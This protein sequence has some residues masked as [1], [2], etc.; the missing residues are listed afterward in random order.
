MTKMDPGDNPPESVPPPGGGWGGARGRLASLKL[1]LAVQ[2]K[3]T[4]A[5]LFVQFP[6]SEMLAVT[7]TVTGPAVVQMNVG[8]A[9]AVPLSVPLPVPPAM[10]HEKLTSELL[11]LLSTPCAKR[12]MTPPTLAE[13]GL[14]ERDETAAHAFA[15]VTV[16]PM[17]TDPL[18]PASTLVAAQT[19]LAV[20]LLVELAAMLK[21]ADPPQLRPLDVVALSATV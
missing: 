18:L 21:A 5:V 17:L 19:T 10:A 9:V 4:E 2:V 12:P 6:A 1:A 15:T 14:A 8:F 16:P 3:A 20:T 13:E 11:P 7:V